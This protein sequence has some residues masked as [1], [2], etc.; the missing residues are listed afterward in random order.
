MEVAKIEA[1]R[2][3]ASEVR[4]DIV[5]MV[6]V[7]RSG[8]I[9][10]PLSV[11]DVLTFLYCEEMNVGPAVCQ[12]RTRDRFLLGMCAATPALY[13]V[14]AR[15]GYFDREELW[16]YKRLG[17]LL[18]PLPEFRRVPGIDAPCVRQPGGIALLAGL[19]RARQAA[20]IDYRIFCFIEIRDCLH[21]VFWSEIKK[22]RE[23]DLRGTVLLINSP[24]GMNG[25]GDSAAFYAAKFAAAGWSADH[26]DGHDFADMKQALRRSGNF[27]PT[28][29]AIFLST[30]SGKGLS[31]LEQR[32]ARDFR[33]KSFQEMEN[34]LEELENGQ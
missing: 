4:K 9:E 32:K 8:T 1:L 22:I 11:A 24:L 23:I 10:T 25:K 17:A 34:A 21:E 20:G 27:S 33:L 7:A 6:G 28:P 3:F 26:A 31:L 18:Q 14:L 30:L 5:R 16:H 15:K 19:A 13:A 2:E 29:K 12:P